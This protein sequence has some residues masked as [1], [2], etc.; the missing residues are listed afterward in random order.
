L[1]IITSIAS[2]LGKLMTDVSFHRKEWV[3]GIQTN[4]GNPFSAINQQHPFLVKL[5]CPMKPKWGAKYGPEVVC[6]VVPPVLFDMVCAGCVWREGS[7]LLYQG[8]SLPL[9]LARPSFTQR[10]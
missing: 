4:F 6:M 7:K 9:S 1:D 8:Q 10:N 2:Y 5:P 3:S